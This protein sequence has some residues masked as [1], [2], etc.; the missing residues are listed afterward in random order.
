[1]KRWIA[2]ITVSLLLLTAVFTVAAE[3]EAYTVDLTGDT[4]IS[5][6]STVTYLVTVQN[7]RTDI[8][9]IGVELE[10]TYDTEVFDFVSGKYKGEAPDQWDLP[11]A[12]ERTE[13][14]VAINAA[15]D[16]AQNGIGSN[17]ALVY[18]LTFTVK[19]T[20]K[21]GGDIRVSYAMAGAYVDGGLAQYEGKLSALT[22]TVRRP[23]PVPTA[24]SW[25]NG[26]AT[27]EAMENVKEF[28]VVLFH[29]E[30]GSQSASEIKIV[31]A[32]GNATSYDFSADMTESGNYSFRVLAMPA[33]DA[34][35]SESESAMSP[36]CPIVAKLKVPQIK[37]SCDLEKGGFKYQI[38][39][40]NAASTVEQYILTV[41][42][43]GTDEVVK[44]VEATAL[45]GH[46]PCDGTELKLDMICVVTVSAV[47]V[48]ENY[49][50]PSDASE[51]SNAVK[52]QPQLTS[53]TVTTQPTLSYKEE[54]AL[55]LTAVVIELV[56]AD[57]T[58]KPVPFADFAEN[59]LTVDMAEGTV[60]SLDDNGK[61]ITVSYGSRTVKTDALTVESNACKHPETHTE[62]TEPTCGKA[63]AEKTVCN[64]CSAVIQ[65]TV[66][67]A[68][69]EHTYGEWVIT[70]NPTDVFKGE[71][72]QI[73]EVCEHKVTEVI[74]VI[75]VTD[76][77]TTEPPQTDPSETTDLPGDQTTAPSTET[78]P[79]TTEPV[80]SSLNDLSKI[81][82]GVVVAIFVVIIL[83]LVIG[84][85]FESSRSK[86][87]RSR[88][89]AR[90]N[91]GNRRPP[92]RR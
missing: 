47:P 9:L 2:V 78:E 23:L 61:K 57:G 7:I 50:L 89:R 62:R 70:Q 83:F 41:Y 22:A 6:G 90:R 4:V 20:E 44:T 27:W 18:A 10:L 11:D 34:P 63:G 3:T 84:F 46:I 5:E 21:T 19:S 36:D 85:W 45:A 31:E 28:R 8:R 72:V 77:I 73:C 81:F 88:A 54:Q 39:D 15:N 82:L 26:K 60:L 64:S 29:K 14:T 42:K 40:T 87:R 17:D 80:G 71:R 51:E 24:L 86:R 43:E 56:F 55:D 53:M 74:P 68:T 30:Y 25:D 65:N 66:L 32:A 92:N 12:T 76:P 13:G 91:A 33:A 37:I 35:Y 79:T 67:P 38:T 75:T 52:V 1:M 49:Y 16:S 59:Y 48:N 58:T 69:G